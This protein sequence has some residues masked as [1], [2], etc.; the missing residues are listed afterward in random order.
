[1]GRK[2]HV[3]LHAQ[4]IEDTTCQWIGEECIYGVSGDMIMTESGK[5][6]MSPHFACSA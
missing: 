2:C 5:S 6:N 1:M 3:L 4:P